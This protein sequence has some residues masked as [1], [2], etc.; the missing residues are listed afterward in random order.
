MAAYIISVANHDD[1]QTTALYL[2]GGAVNGDDISR[3]T[4]QLLCDSVIQQAAWYDLSAPTIDPI[5]SPGYEVAFRPGVTDNEAE[6]IAIGAQRL[7]ISGITQIRT[8]RRTL[9]ATPAYNELIQTRRAVDTHLSN[10]R[11]DFYLQLLAIPPQRPAHIAVVP[12]RTLDDAA[13]LTLSQKSLLALDLIEMRTVQAYYQRID[14]DPSDGELE[15]IAQ[16]WSEHCSHKT[17]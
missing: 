8:V 6:S 7:G 14:R 13:L 11:R 4:T 1:A 17:F 5:T 3:L 12:I 9:G 10:E 2:I 15:T 16:T